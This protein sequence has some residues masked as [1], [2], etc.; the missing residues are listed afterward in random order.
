M[1]QCVEGGFW[2]QCPRSSI[3]RPTTFSNSKTWCM[4][5]CS[6]AEPCPILCNPWNCSPPV[7]SVH[8]ILQA[9]TLQFAKL[10]ESF[11]LSHRVWKISH[12][13][14]SS[15]LFLN[16]SIQHHPILNPHLLYLLCWQAGSLPLS[17]LGSP[18]SKPLLNPKSPFLSLAFRVTVVGSCQELFEHE[19]V[20]YEG[21]LAPSLARK[22]PVWGICLFS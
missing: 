6:V 7:S 1:T 12:S 20:L 19:E 21:N 13:Y 17:H 14:R 15:T 4:R 5:A 18:N 22:K 10:N 9:R 16:I 11:L 8:G 2:K 3:S